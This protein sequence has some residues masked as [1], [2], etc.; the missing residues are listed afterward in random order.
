M[1]D[2][3]LIGRTLHGDREA[4]EVLVQRHGPS[5][6][7]FLFRFL[8]DPDDVAD[9]TQ[10]VFL[11]AWRHLDRFDPGRGRFRNW[12]FRI[13]SNT[14]VNQLRSR[15]RRRE[16]QHQAVAGQDRQEF[17]P[18][19]RLETEE[20]CSQLRAAIGSLPDAERQVV[21]LACYHELPYREV[22]A[23]LDIPVGTVKSRMHSAVGRLRS[24]LVPREV[25]E[26][27]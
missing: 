2:T 18:V 10:E 22:A 1:D 26:V 8:S 23:I 21:L 15:R 11:Q 13:A 20:S 27:S 24:A 7:N 9:L 19:E 16:R 25:G 4:F 14:A 17:P 12:L 5:I 6:H 3:V